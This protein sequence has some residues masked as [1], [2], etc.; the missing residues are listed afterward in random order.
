MKRR[1]VLYTFLF[2]AGFLMTACTQPQPSGQVGQDAASKTQATGT[3]SAVNLTFVSYGVAKPLYSKIIPAFQADWKEKTGQQ[4][5]FKESYG[6][7]GAQTRAILGGLEA[8]ILAQN[9]QSNVAPLVEKGFVAADWSKRLPNQAS[10]ANTVMVLVTRPGNPKQI[11]DWRDLAKDGVSI[12]AINPQTSGNA[13]WGILAGYGALAKA[14]GEPAANTYLNG[15][16]KN[17]KTLVGNGREATDA[18]VKNKIG[19]VLVTFENEI[20]FTNDAIPDDYPYIVPTN[21]I[22][23]DFPVTVIDKTVDKRGTRKVAEAFTAFLFTP[24][25]QEIFAQAG[26]RPIDKQAFATKSSQYKPV[27]KLYTIADFGGWQAVNK[28]LFADGGLFDV[29]QAAGKP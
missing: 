29:A 3:P 10:P 13:R 8:D 27:D 20:I 16:A 22:Q 23:V 26:Y 9:I 21:N 1:S 11:S 19:D 17:I 15:F 12:V 14:E 24:K 2:T 5:T 4:V 25:A 6:A 28:K 7:S 18:F